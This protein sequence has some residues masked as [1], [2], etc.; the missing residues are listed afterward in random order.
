MTRISVVMIRHLWWY[1]EKTAKI[2]SG[3][4]EKAAVKLIPDP[5]VNHPATQKR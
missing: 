4:L 2:W 1:S 5:E 3:K